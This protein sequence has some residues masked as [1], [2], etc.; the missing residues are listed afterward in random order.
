MLIFGC[1]SL[2]LC[3]LNL[4][5]RADTTDIS[6]L[7]VLISIVVSAVQ[8]A[9]L[10]LKI[11]NEKWMKNLKRATSLVQS[12]NRVLGNLQLS[13][14]VVFEMIPPNLDLKNAITVYNKMKIF[15]GR[16]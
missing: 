11:A 1:R 5:N 16:D 4:I 9:S 2:W 10:T 6:L 14:P 15:W 7:S 13:G 3:R 8:T 12:L